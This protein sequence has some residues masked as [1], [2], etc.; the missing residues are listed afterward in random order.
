MIFEHRT[1]TSFWDCYARLP[2]SLQ[3]RADKQ[4]D[5]LDENSSHPS[6]QL[7]P[8]GEFWSARVTNGCR[9]LALRRG[10]VFTWFWIGQHDEYDRLVNGG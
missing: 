2:E 5:L 6:V 3:D 1:T 4:F 8:V 10:I 9:A 7:K